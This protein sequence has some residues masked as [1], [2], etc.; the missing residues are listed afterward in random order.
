MKIPKVLFAVLIAW[1]LAISAQSFETGA[2]LGAGYEMKILKGW[3]WGVEAEARF[4]NNFTHLDRF[5]AGVGTDYAFWHKRLKVGVGYDYLNYHQEDFYESRHRVHG[6]LTVAEKFGPVKLSY[7][8]MFQSTFRNGNRGDYRFNPK[9]YMRNRLAFSYKFAGKP[10]KL[11]ATE[12]FWWRL[13]HPDNNIIDALRTTI[14]V[15]YEVNIHNTLDFFIRSKNEV[16]VANPRHILYI[17]MTYKF[18]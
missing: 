15:E 8:A 6:A 3:H 16:Q 10:V 2:L 1:P 12:E 7:R 18:Q 5:K 11:Y 4:D 13:Y 17:G 9:T 14:G